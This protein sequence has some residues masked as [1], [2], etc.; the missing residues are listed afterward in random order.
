MKVRPMRL[1]LKLMCEFIRKYKKHIQRDFVNVMKETPF[2]AIFL[3]FYNEE[4]GADKSMKSNITVLKI[5]D[6]YDG[7]SRTFL[8]RGKLIELTVEDVTLTFS[9]P[10]NETDF[11][12]NKTCTLNDRGVIKHYFSNINKITKIFIEEVLDDFLVKKR[13]R[14]ELDVTKDEQLEQ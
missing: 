5:V 9:L 14:A 8:T 1:S 13:M 12:T 11:I 10:I 7:K 2:Y 4:F 6:Q 3:A